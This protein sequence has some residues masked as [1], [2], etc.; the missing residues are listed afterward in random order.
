MANKRILFYSSVSEKR[1][2]STQKFYTIDIELLKQ[3]GC[4]VILSNRIF[5]ALK[6]WKYDILFGYFFRYSLFPGIIARLLRKQVYLTGGIDALDKSYAGEKAYKLQVILF[7]LCYFIANKSIIV[8]HSDLHNIKAIAPAKSW[9]KLELSEHS[10]EIEKFVSQ[11]EKKKLFSTIGWQGTEEG[12]KRKGIDISL[13]IFSQLRKTNRFS[14][15]QYVIIGRKGA[16]TAYLEQLIKD[17]EIS[18]A[19]IIT[20]EITEEEKVKTLKES[21]FYFQ[22]SRYEG[23]GLA[24]LEAFCANNVLLHSGKGGLNNPLYREQEIIF[25]IDKSFDEAYKS[26]ER[27]L[28]NYNQYHHIS[29]QTIGYYSNQR[30]KE[31]FRRIMKL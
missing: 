2:F 1:L 14:D 20:D 18:D 17:L 26:F 22:T 15:Y 13:K 28:L 11:S 30:R 12:I 8:S 23:F 27:H 10:I 29:L 9:R 25:D 21:E 24:A 16:G 6:F 19:V 5:D 4:T 7:R 31:D 3:L